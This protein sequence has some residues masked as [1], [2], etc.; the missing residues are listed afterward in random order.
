MRARSL[1][2]LGAALL[3]ASVA[4][5]GGT[6]SNGVASKPSNEILAAAKV[7][8]AS[9]KSV[10]LSGPLVVAGTPVLLNLELVTGSGP[11]GESGAG[12]EV[13][14][15]GV[16]FEFIALDGALY[17]TGGPA[18][19]RRLG[20]LPASQLFQGRWLKA[21]LN[22][23]EFSSLSSL[24]NMGALMS[25]LLNSHGLL[26]VR[27]AGRVRG[28]KAVAVTNVA[29]GETVYVATTGKPYPLE[30]VKSGSD[31]GQIFFDGWNSIAPLTRPANAIE[32][33]PLE[34]T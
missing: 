29:N 30:V 23:G 12:G 15:H 33:G 21:P 16:S 8:A 6:Q 22:S 7:A 32:I 34:R 24:T 19:L 20:G 28:Q 25:M 5:C 9:A 27:A 18:F 2:A 17:I 13:A 4:G 10:H 31:G 1:V 3:V 14:E 26:R 11:G